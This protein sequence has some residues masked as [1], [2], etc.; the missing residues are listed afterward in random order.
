MNEWAFE[1]RL[2]AHLEA[3]G[4][5]VARQLGAGVHAPGNR[6]VD[7]V[8]VEPGPAFDGRAALT[9]H[10][11]PGLVL[12]ADLGAGRARYWKDAVRGLDA[13]P[14][15]A[16]EAVDRAVE[17]GF[18]EAERRGGRTYV[19]QAARYPDEWFGGLTAIE[20]KPDLAS[21]GD[22]ETQLRTD[23][24][25]GLVDRVVLATASHVTG[26][27]RNRLP[28]AVGL[29]RFHPERDE[30]EVLRE[31]RQLPVGE[32]GIELLER[33][34]ARDDVAVVPPAAK[35]RARRRLAERAYGKGWRPG[36]HAGCGH[37]REATVAGVGGLTRCAAFDRLVDPA[38][39]CGAGCPAYEAADPPA[40]DPDA[41]RDEGSP[42]VAEPAGRAREQ[43]SLDAFTAE[44]G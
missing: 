4:A 24:S 22:L 2:C 14:E 32:P 36:A 9:P 20:N 26:A 18:L 10:E 42:W 35:A 37:A 13:H 11:I 15:R 23:V 40:V 1:Q 7:V 6:V 21:P 38:T 30:L 39:D 33:R 44:D 16:R 12:E 43:G 3:R 27:H 19:R 5:L 34:P 41:A 29:W 25:L 31:P 28:E 17:I 8:R